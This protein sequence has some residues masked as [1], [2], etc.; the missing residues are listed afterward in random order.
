M[1][2]NKKPARS[3]RKPPVPKKKNYSPLDPA[4]YP[5]EPG[6]NARYLKNALAI[7]KLPKI[8]IFDQEQVDKRIEE[9]FVIEAGN[10][11]KPTVSGLAMALGISREE[12][13]RVRTGRFQED[14][15]GVLGGIAGLPKGVVNS[16]KKAYDILSRLW[17]DYMQNGK[18]NPM[19]GIF[20]GVNNYGMKNTKDVVIE[21]A[22]DNSDSR[23]ESELIKS[24]GL[25]P[26]DSDS[27]K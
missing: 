7:Y 16:I 9:Y 27:E 21:T 26:S 10:D 11:N 2:E 19:A 24:A 23:T 18:V 20:L 15:N 8:D 6:D 12:L 22:T 25:L 5:V 3:P 1:A 4:N 13:W 14:R 17:E